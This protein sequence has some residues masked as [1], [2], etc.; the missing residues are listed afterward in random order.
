LYKTKKNALIHFEVVT[1]V[2]FRTMIGRKKTSPYSVADI[3][4][5]WTFLFLFFSSD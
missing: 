3:L 1:A 4:L 5:Y 2:G